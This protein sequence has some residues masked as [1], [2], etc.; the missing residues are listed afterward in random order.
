MKNKIQETCACG[1][2]LIYEEEVVYSYERNDK[3]RQRD[4][5]EAHK[6]CRIVGT[7]KQVVYESIM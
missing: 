1:A 4:F 3:N 7:N 2:F 5:Q 6:P